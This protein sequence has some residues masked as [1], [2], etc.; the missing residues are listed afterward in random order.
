[1]PRGAHVY[2][3]WLAI[4]IG[5]VTVGVWVMIRYGLLTLTVALT[6]TFVLNT[7]PITFD[8]HAW[9]ADQSLYVLAIVAAVAT[10]GFVTARSGTLAR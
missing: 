1:M 9:Y 4:G 2:T 10:Y 5:G 7:S 6:V 8:L 3:S